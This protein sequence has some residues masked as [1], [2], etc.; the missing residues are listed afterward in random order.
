MSS[1]RSALSIFNPQLLLIL[2]TSSVHVLEGQPQY[3]QLVAATNCTDATDT[4][5]CL[6]RSLSDIIMS[7]IN[8]TPNIFSY[9]SMANGWKPRVDGDMLKEDPFVALALGHYAKVPII[10]GDCDDEGT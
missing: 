10:A 5:D 8:R 6:R 9:S 3:D 1:Q 2:G 7:A 4:L